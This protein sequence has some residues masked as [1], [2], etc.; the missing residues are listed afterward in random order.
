M[1]GSVLAV[2]LRGQ[3][4]IG[5]SGTLHRL[6]VGANAGGSGTPFLVRN[7]LKMGVTTGREQ[8]FWRD[9]PM[10]REAKGRLRATVLVGWIQMRFHPNR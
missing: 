9:D 5:S 1:F 8:P 2:P 6:G 4:Y 7:T 3:P 10:R